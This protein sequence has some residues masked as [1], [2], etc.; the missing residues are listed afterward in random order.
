M[1]SRRARG[2]ARQR[3][4]RQR[5]GA[6]RLSR[7][8]EREHFRATLEPGEPDDGNVGSEPIDKSIWFSWQ[9]PADA[10][11]TIDSCGTFSF[12]TR[13][14]AFT[15]ASLATLKRVHGYETN[16]GPVCSGHPSLSFNAVKGVRYAIAMF[17]EPWVGGPIELTVSPTPPPANDDFGDP[18]HEQRIGLHRRRH[19]CRATKE[20]GEP[21]H[22]GDP[23]GSSVWFT[24]VAPDS[25]VASLSTCGSTFDAV[26]MAYEGDQVGDLRPLGRLLPGYL[27]EPSRELRFGVTAGQTYRFALDGSTHGGTQPP[28]VGEYLIRAHVGLGYP[29]NDEFEDAWQ[30]GHP[31]SEGEWKTENL[32]ATREAGEPL[33]AGRPGSAS[34][35]WG[36]SSQISGPLS[37]DTCQ[38]DFDTLLAV[39]EG[40]TLGTLRPL[41]ANDDS[42]GPKCAGGKGSELSFYADAGKTYWVAVDGAGGAVG[43]FTL[44]WKQTYTLPPDITPPDTRLIRISYRRGH[45]VVEVKFYTRDGRARLRCRLDHHHSQSCGSPQLYTDLPAG[46]HKL[47]VLAIDQAGNRDPTPL[48]VRFRIAPPPR[49]RAG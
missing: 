45:R 35:W 25:G 9:A 29:Q 37:L 3:R 14:A 26:L 4:L 19:E 5:A 17:G 2:A 27:C 39:Y 47:V 40:A 20:A 43:N 15:E 13:L 44:R 28:E 18:Y 12:G 31:I 42:A 24:W 46:P 33:H 6:K 21:Q 38:A 1:G 23:G 8:R 16:Y 34:L 36:M 32:E 22:G 7:E 48:V 41:V 30:I 10:A 49:G 11:V